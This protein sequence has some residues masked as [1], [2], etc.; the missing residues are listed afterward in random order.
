M[1]CKSKSN[2]FNRNLR[3]IIPQIFELKILNSQNINNNFI[4]KYLTSIRRF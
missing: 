4:K 2:T 1:C 3:K